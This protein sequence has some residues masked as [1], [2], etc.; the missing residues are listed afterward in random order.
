MYRDMVEHGTIPDCL[1]GGPITAGIQRLLASTPVHPRPPAVGL[2]LLGRVHR[3]H[4][5]EGLGSSTEGQPFALISGAPYDERALLSPLFEAVLHD[6]DL[7]LLPDAVS[8]DSAV[9]FS[10]AESRYLTRNDE[11]KDF[12]LELSASHCKT[13]AYRFVKDPEGKPVCIR[14]SRLLS[15]DSDREDG[16]LGGDVGDSCLHL[17]D[18]GP[19][20][21]VSTEEGRS[22][23]NWSISSRD[24][25][26]MYTVLARSTDTH[27]VVLSA[28]LTKGCRMSLL[29][30]RDS[31]EAIPR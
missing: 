19:L 25:L 31:R 10:G 29:R 11:L 4:S 6:M 21:S 28:W 24:D 9:R 26:D 16:K 18:S 12:I 27:A 20:L 15:P 22:W 7:L 8:L 2:S 13:K 1:N 17:E 14:Y 30:L 23:F 5:Q 3:A